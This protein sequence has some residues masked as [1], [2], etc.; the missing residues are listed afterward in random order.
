MC[1]TVEGFLTPKEP[2]ANVKKEFFIGDMQVSINEDKVRV[3]IPD[4]KGSTNELERLAGGA[5]EGLLTLLSFY[6]EQQFKF[7]VTRSSV[8]KES[9]GRTVVVYCSVDAYIAGHRYLTDS[10][11]DKALC[12]KA[13]VDDN[14]LLQL[15][16]EDY[17]KAIGSPIHYAIIH[18]F[19]AYEAAKHYFGGESQMCQELG[20]TKNFVE[21]VRKRAN[22]GYY[23]LRHAPHRDEIPDLRSLPDD[24]VR[25]CFSRVKQL[26]ENWLEYLRKE[27][28]A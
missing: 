12:Y 7:Q 13:L 5:L 3:K 26:L 10:I 11:W 14:I 28:K 9:G 25:E 2:F 21:Y 19:R 24:E 17:I 20:F 8:S 22:A 16:L 6:S 27:P 1:A 4:F 18:L 15:A 23:N